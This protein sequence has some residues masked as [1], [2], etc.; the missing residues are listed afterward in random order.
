M[1]LGIGMRVTPLAGFKPRSQL[2]T[3]AG[4]SCSWRMIVSL[5]LDVKQ[6][7]KYHGNETVPFPHKITENYQSKQAKCIVFN[8]LVLYRN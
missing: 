5:P 8:Y 2:D 7:R 3:E 4:L 6:N 1:L